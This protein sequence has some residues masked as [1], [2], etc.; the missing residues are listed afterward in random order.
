MAKGIPQT[1][2]EHVKTIRILTAQM[3][4]LRQE[5][6]ELKLAAAQPKTKSGRQLP[7]TRLPEGLR[8]LEIGR[9]PL[10]GGN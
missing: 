5:V 9:D 1:V 4:V 2:M 7:P 10:Q 6:D 3:V 8:R